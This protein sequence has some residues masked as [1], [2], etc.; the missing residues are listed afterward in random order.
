MALQKIPLELV[1]GA[2]SNGNNTAGGM[3]WP[4][5]TPGHVITMA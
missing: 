5:N 2:Q 3:R 1:A 4:K